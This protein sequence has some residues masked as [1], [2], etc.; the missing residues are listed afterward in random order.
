MQ[1]E[2]WEYHPYLNNIMISNLGNV[3]NIKPY[4]NQSNK[5]LKDRSGK[6]RE[7]I[8]SL[9]QHS[10][11]YMYV[12]IHVNGKSKSFR[13]HRLVAET[14]I[15]NYENKPYVNH[16]DGDKTNNRVENLEWVTSKENTTHAIRTG[17]MDVD[18]HWEKVK[19][20]MVYDN[21]KTIYMYDKIS[22]EFCKEFPSIRSCARWIIDQ[23]LSAGTEKT[24]TCDI[25]RV[26]SN[27]RN[28]AYGYKF[29]YEKL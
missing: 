3:K 6:S 19:D 9:Y 29:Y 12:S 17:L 25:H 7:K 11:G 21:G 16:I 5:K 8:L 1:E 26:L 22:N 10:S 24:V 15:P 2:I 4:S 23:G 27:K 18:K 28:S 20:K 14:F 13:V